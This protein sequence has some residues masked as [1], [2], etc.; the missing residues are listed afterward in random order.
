MPNPDFGKEYKDKRNGS[1]DR[2]Y[3]RHL[4]AREITEFRRAIDT[5]GEQKKSLWPNPWNHLDER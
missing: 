5:A 4:T 3:A 2:V 1:G